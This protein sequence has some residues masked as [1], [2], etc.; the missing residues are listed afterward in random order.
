MKERR[1]REE[2]RDG[3]RKREG[4]GL[5]EDADDYDLVKMITSVEDEK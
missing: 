4:T 3:E 1:K 2:K 5:K